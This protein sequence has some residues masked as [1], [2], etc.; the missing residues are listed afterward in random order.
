MPRLAPVN[1]P[2]LDAEGCVAAAVWSGSCTLIQRNGGRWSAFGRGLWVGLLAVLVGCHARSPGNRVMVIGL[3]GLDPSVVGRLITEGRLPNLARLQAEGAY[4][5]LRASDALLLSPVLW[6]TI[7]TGKP[8]SDHGLTHFAAVDPKSG[9]PLPV[10]SRMR[11]VKALWQIASAAGRTVATVGWWATWPAESVRGAVVSDHTC[12][13]FL[14]PE[15]ARGADAP[16][17]VTHPPELFSK[18]APLVRRPSDI[19]PQ[20]LAGF[21][22]VEPQELARPFD[23]DDPVSHLRWALASADSYRRIGLQLWREQR[24]DLLLLYV[25]APDSVSHLFGHLFRTS[26]LAGELAKEQERYGRAVEATYVFADQLVGEY[27]ESMDERTTLIVLSDHG[28]ALGV[29][30]EDPSARDLRRVSERYHRREGV[31]FLRGAGIKRGAALKDAQ[32]FDVA[33]TV[34]A[35]LGLAEAKDMPGRALSEALD[36]V[37]PAPSIATYESGESRGRAADAT[38][39]AVDPEIMARL[40]SLGYVDARSSLQGDRN[41]AEQLFAD[42][43]F[44]EAVALY[45]ELLPRSPKDATLHASLAGALAALEQYPEALREL[46]QALELDPLGAAARYNRGA[47]FENQGQRAQALREYRGALR[48]QPDYAPAREA[49]ARL[50]EKDSDA[51]TPTAAES[52]AL[53]LAA[54][55]R[56]AGQ[57]EDYA[58]AARLLD[59]A[60]RKAPRLALIHHF[61]ANIAYLR[62]DRA[63]A[64][65]ALKQALA[66]EPD[67]LLYARNL[68]ALEQGRSPR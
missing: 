25:E 5:V 2:T 29:L 4:G 60:E 22:D 12:Y 64:I 9:R 63:G 7:A 3:D 48:Y 28:F 11:R 40:Q 19:G 47:I 38:G 57:R 20:E 61:R 66:L 26:G 50:G 58:K 44:E 46:D 23:F 15:A 45:R 10:T 1:I 41:R 37:P 27:I 42:G 31:L 49:L 51:P 62:G 65:T 36:F 55:A 56:E 39:D 30:P 52:Q 32:H 6:T 35:L 13:H 54:Q 24:P 8:A 34:L 68:R 53:A 59:E 43:R 17:G 14:F 18:I 21:V 67:N 16:V 33:P